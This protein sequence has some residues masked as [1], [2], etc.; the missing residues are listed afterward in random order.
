[1]PVVPSN[2]CELDQHCCLGVA[3]PGRMRYLHDRSV[4]YAWCVNN[5]HVLIDMG[6]SEEPL[7]RASSTCP[8]R[9]VPSASVRV[10]ISLYLGNLTW[11]K[12]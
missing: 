7:P 3:V 1:M 8:W 4:S 10:T 2:T 6:W 11:R 12:D 5:R 9:S